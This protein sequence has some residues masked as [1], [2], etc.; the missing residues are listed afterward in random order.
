M[1]LLHNDK[2]ALGGSTGQPTN[3]DH[4]NLER[5]RLVLGLLALLLSLL[6]YLAI[7]KKPVNHEVV[8]GGKTVAAWFNEVQ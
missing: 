2:S 3:C 1:D 5:R 7:G 6:T 8:Y 4:F